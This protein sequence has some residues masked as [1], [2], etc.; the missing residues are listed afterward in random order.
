MSGTLHPYVKYIPIK[1]ICFIVA[2]VL[3]SLAFLLVVWSV[4]ELNP[5]GFVALGLAVKT[6]GRMI[7]P[8]G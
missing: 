1:V 5:L 6:T 7:P 3:F 4:K 8:A 2:I